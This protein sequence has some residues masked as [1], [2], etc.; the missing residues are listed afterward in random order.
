MSW[1]ISLPKA[2]RRLGG[3]LCSGHPAARRSIARTALSPATR[4]LDHLLRALLPAPRL[5]LDAVPPCLLLVAPPRSGSTLIYQV[6]TQVLPCVYPANLHQLFPYTASWWMHRWGWFGSRAEGFSSYYGHTTSLKDVNEANDWTCWV[7]AAPSGRAGV[8]QRFLRFVRELR[9]TGALP[10]VWKNVGAY[11]QLPRLIEAVP[12]LCFLRVRRDPA[13]I[14]QSELRGYRDLGTFHPIPASM[15]TRSLD[16][17][18]AFA[19]ELILTIDAELDHARACSAPGQWEEWSY[20][21]F[22]MH[23][24]AHIEDLA[25]RRYPHLLSRLSQERIAP[26]QQSTRP[27]VSG[28][29]R[30]RIKHLLA[31]RRAA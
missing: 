10:L 6:L 13:E 19:V 28:P 21:G 30:E 8:R 14:V 3:A 26:L 16:D 7:L 18:V 22:C 12:E 24:L 2:P 11:D 27:R 9:P 1:T 29:E 25:Q 15:R 4:L 23:P 20:E 5:T 31:E 17:P